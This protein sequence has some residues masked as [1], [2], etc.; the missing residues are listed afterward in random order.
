MFHLTNYN[1]TL[2]K[3]IQSHAGKHNYNQYNCLLAI[4]H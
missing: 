2:K 3:E 1:K 4:L